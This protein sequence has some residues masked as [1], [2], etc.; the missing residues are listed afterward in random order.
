[1][2]DTELFA[3]ATLVNAEIA[4]MIAENMIRAKRGDSLAY[5]DMAMSQ[6]DCVKAL[7]AELRN[8][9]VVQ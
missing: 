5:N 9:F 7:D 3:L 8:R 4:A 6:L 2:N 1:M